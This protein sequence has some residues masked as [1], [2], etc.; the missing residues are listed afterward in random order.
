MVIEYIGKKRAPAILILFAASLVLLISMAIFYEE[1]SWRATIATIILMVVTFLMRIIVSRLQVQANDKRGMDMISKELEYLLVL[2]P[3]V[4]TNWFVTYYMVGSYVNQS[5][6]GIRFKDHFISILFFASLYLIIF[7]I[8]HSFRFTILIQTALW[9]VYCVFVYKTLHF[10]SA[11]EIMILAEMTIVALYCFILM[12]AKERKYI[13]YTTTFTSGRR[14]Y[15]GLLKR[16]IC[17]AIAVFLIFAV[18]LM[19]K[20]ITS[21]DAANHGYIIEKIVMVREML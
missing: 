9:I 7:A 10:Q 14:P 20:N 5:F 1:I 19:T 6:D 11:P 16:I 12:I 17:L 3:T 2:I 4:A 18:F 21:S 8:T 15:K 13:Y